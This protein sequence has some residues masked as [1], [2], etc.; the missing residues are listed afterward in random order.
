MC[1]DFFPC[2]YAHSRLR[3]HAESVAF[4]GGGSREQAVVE[5][6]FKTLLTHSHKLLRK[7]WVFGIADEFLTKQL[8]HNVTWGLSLLYAVEHGG[9]RA[10]VSVQAELAHDLRFLA[11]VVS[12][13]FLAFGDIMELYRKFVE[14]SGGITRVSELEELLRAAQNGECHYFIL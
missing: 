7:R 8:P 6:R 2:R 14:L 12:Q 5:G 11:S 1:C 10:Q 13:S 4:F 3:T 9:D